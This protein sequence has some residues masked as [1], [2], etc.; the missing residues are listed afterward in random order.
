MLPG[1]V[2]E[3]KRQNEAASEKMAQAYA[4]MMTLEQ[5]SQKISGILSTITDISSETE[6]LA[7]NASIEAARAGEH[8]KGFAVVA[9]SIGKL[10]ANSSSATT[11]IEEIIVELCRDISEAV[12]NIELVRTGM[13]QQTQ[14][15]DTVQDTFTDFN[16][17]AEKTRESVRGMEQ[18]IEEMHE[19]D[20]SVVVAVERIRGI[21]ANTAEL[22]QKAADYLEKQSDKIRNVADRIDHLSMVSEEMEQE[23]TKFKL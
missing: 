1:S 19:C 11:D 15:V 2:A 3:L 18:L 8:G 12:E 16:A 17:L 14:V 21:S 10:A 22:T 4:K 20:N 9:E 23:M 6:L 7:L 13:T 5:Q